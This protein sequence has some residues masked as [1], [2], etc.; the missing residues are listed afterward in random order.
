MKTIFYAVIGV[1]ATF[2]EVAK[3]YAN[4]GLLV[5]DSPYFFD[6]NLGKIVKL[7]EFYG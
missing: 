4:I 2:W 7:K 1:F 3:F 5:E 6:R